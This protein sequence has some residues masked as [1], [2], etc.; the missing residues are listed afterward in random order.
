[1]DSQSND[2]NINE[3]EEIST[4]RESV[5]FHTETTSTGRKIHYAS[6]HSIKA[7]VC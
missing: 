1:M 4:Q 5:V 7:P 2:I 3:S 6:H